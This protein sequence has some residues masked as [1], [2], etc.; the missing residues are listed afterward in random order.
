MVC[1]SIS[2]HTAEDFWRVHVSDPATARQ[3]MSTTVAPGESF[4]MNLIQEAVGG[5]QSAWHHLAE[6]GHNNL[7]RSAPGFRGAAF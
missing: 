4:M 2:Q 7:S 5:D 1:V 3:A 6:W